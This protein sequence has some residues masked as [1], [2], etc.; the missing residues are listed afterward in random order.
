VAL[1]MASEVMPA[2]SAEQLAEL[3]P[4]LENAD[5]VELKVSVPEER[6]Q[7]AID[8][9]GMD[10]LDAQIRQVV[11]LDTPGLTLNRDGVVVRVRRIQG[12]PGDSVVKLRPLRPELMTPAL[13][14]SRSL[15]VE[16]DA[17]PNGFVCSGSMKAEVLDATIKQELAR[18]QLHRLFTKTQRT[19]YSAHAPEGLEID[20]LE[21]LGPINLLKLK[22][23]PPDFPG[24]RWV[25][26]LWNYP[27][28]SRILELST[29]CAPSEAF[30]IAAQSK[31]YLASKGV[32]LFAEQQTKTRT[33]LKFFASELPDD[34]AETL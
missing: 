11:F 13:R 23:T 6:R 30:Q 17:M 19:F 3:L 12:K 28:G 15:G 34:G 1:N 8:G 14:R 4:L 31:A 20:D 9:L 2:Y 27:D 22:F 32:D 26:E 25:A 18:R 7:S 33:A 16:V 10:P 24:R 21:V 5:S 29:K